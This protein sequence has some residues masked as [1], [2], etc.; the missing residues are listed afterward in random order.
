MINYLQL[1]VPVNC[2]LFEFLFFL[3]HILIQQFL[4]FFI[5]FQHLIWPFGT[6]LLNSVEMEGGETGEEGWIFKSLHCG[7]KYGRKVSGS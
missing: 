3:S 7:S 6:L 1:D 4:L 2:S 5:I